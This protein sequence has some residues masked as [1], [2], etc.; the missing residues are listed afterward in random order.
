MAQKIITSLVF[1][2][3]MSFLWAV[4]YRL[5]RQ[6]QGLKKYQR[7]GCLSGGCFLP[8]IFVVLAFASGDLGSPFSWPLIAI[9]GAMLGV[10]LGTLYFICRGNK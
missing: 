4:I 2:S 9:L 7:T 1:L 5:A 8:L 3:L 6:S 10:A